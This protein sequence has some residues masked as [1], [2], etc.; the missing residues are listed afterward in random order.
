MPFVFPLTPTMSYIKLFFA[1]S[2]L[3]MALAACRMRDHCSLELLPVVRPDGILEDSC[4]SIWAMSS[5]CKRKFIGNGLRCYIKD[6]CTKRNSW[7]TIGHYVGQKCKRMYRVTQRCNLIRVLQG[8]RCQMWDSCA[9]RIVWVPRGGIYVS[10]CDETIQLDK[11]CRFKKIR[12][13]NRCRI[14]DHCNRNI[15]WEPMGVTL[16]DDCGNPFRIDRK[17]HQYDYDDQF[18]GDSEF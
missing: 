7:A 17:C 5:D 6:P 3:T 14:V 18:G 1:A 2:I 4:G 16:T 15:I 12:S 11:Y 13:G 9:K 10:A 8:N